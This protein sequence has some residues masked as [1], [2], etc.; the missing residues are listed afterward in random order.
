MTKTLSRC[1]TAIAF[2][3]LSFTQAFAADSPAAANTPAD[4][5][6]TKAQ[7]ETLWGQA[8]AG[9]SGDLA[10]DKAQPYVKDFA[11]ADVNS[12]KKLSQAEWLQACDQ[13]WIK[14]A[15]ASSGGAT[16]G[17]ATSD[18]TPEVAP[19]R[20]PGAGTTGAAGTDAGQTTSGTS[21]RTPEKKY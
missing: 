7:C 10:M 6:L 17:G 12:D 15:D 3:T 21:D 8:V 14:T 1:A 13:G 2:G 19:E 5:K 11:K 9:T 16:V 4:M 20:T 18:R